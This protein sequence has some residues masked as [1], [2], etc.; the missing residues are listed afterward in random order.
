[1][2]PS[3]HIASLG[4]SGAQQGINITAHG[5]DHFR[6]SVIN[7]RESVIDF[8]ECHQL[9]HGGVGPIWLWLTEVNGKSLLPNASAGLTPL[10]RISSNL[11]LYIK[12]S[13]GMAVRQHY[14]HWN[15][16]LKGVA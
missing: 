7:F 8:R 13:V 11:Q 14:I 3:S 2:H 1:M 4:I 15:S 16:A 10:Q 12:S 9:Q 6:E 5:G